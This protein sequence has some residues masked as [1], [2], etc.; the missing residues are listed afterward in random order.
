MEQAARV[1]LCLSDCQP[2]SRDGWRRACLS[3]APR[4]WAGPARPVRLRHSRC[5]LAALLRRT[6][7]AKSLEELGIELTM[8]LTP[9][10]FIVNLLFG[11]CF[12]RMGTAKRSVG[13]LRDSALPLQVFKVPWALN[14]GRE[15]VFGVGR[16]SGKGFPS[17]L[18]F[19]SSR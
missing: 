8:L 16:Q 12:H 3:R 13:K 2:P 15:D 10:D 6:L 11:L 14:G 19:L 9:R 17:R 4:L 1:V 5:P 7:G 18:V